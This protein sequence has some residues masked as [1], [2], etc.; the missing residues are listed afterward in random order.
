MASFFEQLRDYYDK[1]VGGVTQREQRETREKGFE[2]LVEWGKQMYVEFDRHFDP[3][4]REA[5][6][7]IYQAAKRVERLLLDPMGELAH[8]GALGSIGSALGKA[9][10]GN[11]ARRIRLRDNIVNIIDAQ[12]Q[13]IAAALEDLTTVVNAQALD[14]KAPLI[15]LRGGYKDG[16]NVNDYPKS[17]QY[18]AELRA[19]IDRADQ[20]LEPLL[21]VDETNAMITQDDLL[22]IASLYRTLHLDLKVWQAALVEFKSNDPSRYNSGTFNSLD[23]LTTD[24]GISGIVHKHE[25]AFSADHRST[26]DKVLLNWL[27]GS[28]F[29]SLEAD[30][31]GTTPSGEI[32]AN[33]SDR[34]GYFATL[35]LSTDDLAE[36]SEAGVKMMLKKAFRKLALSRHPDRNSNDPTAPAKFKALKEAFDTLYNKTT[37]ERYLSNNSS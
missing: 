19:L 23:E 33:F 10:G 18:Q 32:P 28:E 25:R 37:R 21:S 26:R 14:V 1:A 9:A 6:E 29:D 7:H 35:G 15:P 30:M 12:V 22:I 8:D 3:N 34:K 2:G 27:S 13:T 24:D 5:T 16:V 17:K 20:V 31:G 4:N 36:K 11:E